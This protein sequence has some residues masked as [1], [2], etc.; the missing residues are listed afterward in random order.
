[1]MKLNFV[2][3]VNLLCLPA[4]NSDGSESGGLIPCVLPENQFFP[5]GAS[6]KD[7]DCTSCQCNNGLISCFHQSCPPAECDK[8]V[9]RKGQCC[10]SCIGKF[11][12]HPTTHPLPHHLLGIIAIFEYNY[13]VARLTKAS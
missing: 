6:W 5:S 4:D 11:S 12:H 7:D 13:C 8:P 10:A 3:D 1:M 2:F 9:L